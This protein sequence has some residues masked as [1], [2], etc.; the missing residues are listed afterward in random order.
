MKFKG[1]NFLSLE[2]FRK[3]GIGVKTPVW[4][5]QEGDILYLW[6]SADT[7]KLKRIRNNPRVNI[8][9]CKRGGEVT[10]EWM[11]ARASLDESESAVQHVVDLLRQKMGFEF[12]LIGNL[13][14]LAER[15]KGVRRVCVKVS[16]V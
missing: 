3:S 9:P 2:T 14:I 1:E 11:P 6:T 7:G 5:A 13:E 12:F 15:I 4:F 10:G 8:A 16:F